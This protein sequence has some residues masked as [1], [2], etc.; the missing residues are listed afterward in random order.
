[1]TTDSVRRIATA[2]GAMLSMRAPRGAARCGGRSAL[3][4]RLLAVARRDRAG[5][6]R[7]RLG[8]ADRNELD[9]WVLRHYRRG[10]A[11]ARRLLAD[12]YVWAGEERV[13]AFAEWRLLARLHASGC[14]C[15]SRSAHATVAR[16]CCTAAI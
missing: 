8:V 14:R 3:R 15:R 9:Q 4:R 16:D 12:R 7:P 5:R 1:M 2:Q 11:V 13:R 10:G 6:S